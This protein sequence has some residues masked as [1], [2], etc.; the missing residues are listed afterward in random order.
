MPVIWIRGVPLKPGA[1]VPSIVR[2]TVMGGSGCTRLIVS[3]L[4]VRAKSIVLAVV[5][6]FDRRISPRSVPSPGTT[7]VGSSPPT[8]TV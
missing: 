3:A 6:M 7:R 4:P 8:V 2:A 5:C 1:L